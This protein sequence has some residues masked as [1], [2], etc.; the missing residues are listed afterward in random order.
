MAVRKKNYF[1]GVWYL[2]EFEEMLYLLCIQLFPRNSY[3]MSL[4]SPHSSKYINTERK[5]YLNL[6]KINSGHLR[7]LWKKSHKLAIKRPS[8][9]VG[10][11]FSFPFRQVQNDVISPIQDPASHS[12]M[13]FPMWLS[14]TPSTPKHQLLPALKFNLLSNCL[15]RVHCLRH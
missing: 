6:E 13:E 1:S 10:G 9:T 4:T 3:F 15:W 11:K 5:R 2:Y 12:H 7:A 14:C 8:G